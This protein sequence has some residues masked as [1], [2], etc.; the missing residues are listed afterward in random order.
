MMRPQRDYRRGDSLRRESTTNPKRAAA[1]FHAIASREQPRQ[2]VSRRIDAV[3]FDGER[4]ASSAAAAS[5]LA[6]VPPRSCPHCRSENTVHWGSAHRMPR[7]RCTSCAR[8][9]NILTKTPLARLRNKDRWLT[10]VGTMLE[11][12]SIRKSALACGVSATTSLRWHHRFLNCTADQR[13]TIF[14]AIINAYADASALTGLSGETSAANPA[15]G[16]DLLPVLLS[17]I[18]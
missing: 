13:A 8:T 16:K 6:E 7:F 9:F 17:W 11:G 4:E 2:M 10:F 5:L 12:K 15:W 14:G 1:P 18:L 3:P